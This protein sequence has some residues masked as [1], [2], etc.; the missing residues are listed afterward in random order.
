MEILNL[1]EIGNNIKNLRKAKKMSPTELNEEID[2]SGRS[3][4]NNWEKGRNRPNDKYLK[5]LGKFFGIEPI[6]IIFSNND[7]L[8]EFIERTI[9]SNLDSILENKLA[10]KPVKKEQQPLWEIIL[11]YYS[12]I[13][14]PFICLYSTYKANSEILEE[15]MQDN[16]SKLIWFKKEEKEKIIRQLT[17]KGEVILNYLFDWLKKDTLLGIEDKSFDDIA[18][19]LYD[20]IYENDLKI[21]ELKI[22]V[23]YKFFEL[24]ISTEY[25]LFN[26]DVEILAPFQYAKLFGQL[27]KSIYIG[28]W[29]SISFYM[30]LD[31]KRRGVTNKSILA[32]LKSQKKFAF[33]IVNKIIDV[34]SEVAYMQQGGLHNYTDFE[35]NKTFLAFYFKKFVKI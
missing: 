18:E 26:K 17:K 33:E 29:N 15:I 27:I 21:S 22:F 12:T 28:K 9:E 24:K 25:T 32:M 4:I 6:K 34:D 5:S 10:F 35:K 30:G 16:T 13:S 7:Q 1:N 3:A 14:L 19:I 2:T 11:D 23:P 20:T 8:R 31:G